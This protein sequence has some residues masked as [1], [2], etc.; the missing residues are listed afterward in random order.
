MSDH[1]I[2]LPPTFEYVNQF[3]S[4]IYAPHPSLYRCG[5][6]CI[7]MVAE[8][9]F[10][11]RWN[12]Y[13]LMDVFYRADTAGPDTPDNTAGIGATQISAWLKANGVGYVGTTLDKPT[14]QAAILQ[15]CP[16]MLLIS[17]MSQLHDGKTDA[18]LYSWKCAG[19]GHYIVRVGYSDSEPYG[20]YYDPA[21]GNR[22]QPV[23]IR[24]NDIVRSGVYSAWICCPASKNTT[25]I[26]LP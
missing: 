8:I 1:F 2:K 19:D 11:G 22:H 6:A 20:Y 17:D 16:V 4:T 15:N 26:H 21:S 5:G 12:P 23:S 13:E 9:A 18:P 25:D 14:M 24:W 10:P 7:A 3:L